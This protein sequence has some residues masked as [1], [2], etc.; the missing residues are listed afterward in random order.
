MGN[1]GKVR[2]VLREM[3]AVLVD[4]LGPDSAATVL[5]RAAAQLRGTGYRPG[6]VAMNED[7]PV[8]DR[9]RTAANG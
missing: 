8:A 7:K 9:H 1:M 4:E 6:P 2:R 5:E 3:V